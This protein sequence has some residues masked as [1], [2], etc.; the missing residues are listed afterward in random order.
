MNVANA[1]GV[2]LICHHAPLIEKAALLRA[3]RGRCPAAEPL[4]GNRESGSLAFVHPDHPILLTD[5][6]IA[7]QSLI[8]VS[9][10]QFDAASVSAALEQTWDFQSARSRLATC[11][12]TVLVSD[13]MTS[14]LPYRE[15]IDLFHQTIRAVL[16]VIP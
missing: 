2:E 11:T 4:D 15:R 7:A 12:A 8:A 16:D 9:D 1:Y 10:A 3:L 6:C 5:R 13:F 14:G